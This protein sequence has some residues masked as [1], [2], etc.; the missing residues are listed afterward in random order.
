M[1]DISNP[2]I[3][4]KCPV[5]GN[6]IVTNP[7]WD[8]VLPTY[9]I[10]FGVLEKR[11][12]L[13]DCFGS[14][15][16]MTSTIYEEHVQRV[17]SEAILP[18]ATYATCDNYNNINRI[19]AG[20]RKVAV[21][22]FRKHHP[23]LRGVYFYNTPTIISF[24][25]KATKNYLKSHYSLDTKKTYK[26]ALKAAYQSIGLPLFPKGN[27]ENVQ[28]YFT[29]PEWKYFCGQKEEQF[30]IVQNNIIL[31]KFIQGQTFEEIH[32][33]VRI[34]R[35]VIEYIHSTTGSTDYHIIA[36]FSEIK[37]EKTAKR[38]LLIQLMQEVEDNY[39]C[40]SLYLIGA[41]IYTK[42]ALSFMKVFFTYDIHHCKTQE[43]AISV[44]NQPVGL[45]EVVE[46]A[47]DLDQATNLLF[48]FL[49]SISMENRGITKNPEKPTNPNL[50]TTYE[51]LQMFKEDICEVF[52]QRDESEM[53]LKLMG[54]KL[55]A[56]NDELEARV[57]KR[58]EELQKAKEQAESANRTKSD[59]LARISHELRTPMHG[60][61][62]Y[63]KFGINKASK[64]PI[65]KTLS[66]FENIY[67]SGERLMLLVNHLLDLSRLESG[68]MPFIIRPNDLSMNLK[69][70]QS[71]LNQLI[72][73]NEIELIVDDCDFGLISYDKD[74]VMQVFTNLIGNA[75][76]FSEKGG[77][78][79][80]KFQKVKFEE[81]EYAQIQVHDNGV[82]IPEGELDTVF[83]SFSQ[84][85]TTKAK[86]GGSGL[87]LAIS[88]E[89]ISGH[90]G[91]IYAKNAEEKGSIFIVDLPLSL[92]D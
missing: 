12:I 51:S 61:L 65:E 77:T 13:H 74:R 53:N 73:E 40:T 22:N 26:E 70:I 9:K 44:C 62:S 33:K 89:I 37:N 49:S 82:G 20:A 69:A 42:I 68:Q 57:A 92:G 24:A 76:K 80:I 48:D 79:H 90:G 5:T 52:A 36:D 14:P 38:K 71:G 43:E 18:D 86:T 7:E 1:N 75:I 23:N 30:K 4:A 41:N 55:Q 58:T 28:D 17:I 27:D 81:K 11:I 8:I 60:I 3:N 83:E 64:V 56:T 2:Y 35:K 66:Y 32:E 34:G 31:T 72:N 63:S 78:I 47:S 25:V 16:A 50:H 91:R 59:F 21:E 39:P 29:R 84:S 67:D 19:S 45:H 15:T 6:I 88:K 46:P 87:G 10:F 54:E 85:S